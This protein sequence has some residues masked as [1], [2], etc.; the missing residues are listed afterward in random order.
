MKWTLYE[1]RDMFQWWILVS[2]VMN[3]VVH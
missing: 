1:T 3:F 2:T